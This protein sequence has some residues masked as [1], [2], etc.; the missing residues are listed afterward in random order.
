MQSTRIQEDPESAQNISSVVEICKGVISRLGIQ[1]FKIQPSVQKCRILFLITN[2]G[3]SMDGRWSTFPVLIDVDASLVRVYIIFTFEGKTFTFSDPE[4]KRILVEYITMVNKFLRVGLFKFTSSKLFARFEHVLPFKCFPASSWRNLCSNTILNTLASYKAFGLG[5]VKIVDQSERIELKDLGNLLEICSSRFNETNSSSNRGIV[6]VK[7]QAFDESS[8]PIPEDLIEKLSNFKELFDWENLRNDSGKVLYDN[9]KLITLEQGIEKAFNFSFQF[10]QQLF[11]GF[12]FL[13][14][15]GVLF[16][17]LAISLIKINTQGN[18][19]ISYKFGFKGIENALNAQTNGRTEYEL[20]LWKQIFS[21]N[22]SLYSIKA[23]PERNLFFDSIAVTAFK[24]PRLDDPKNLLG[25]GGF[26]TIFKNFLH[27]KPVAIKFPSFR[28]EDQGSSLDRFRQEYLI[29]KYLRHPNIIKVYGIVNYSFMFGI[30]FE[31]CGGGTMNE[32][33]KESKQTPLLEKIQVLIKLSSTLSYVHSKGYAHLDVKPHNVFFQGTQPLLADFGLA[34]DI[35]TE[36]SNEIKLGCTIYYSP[37]EQI[38]GSTPRT[39]FDVWAFGM[40]MYQYLT[41][42]HPFE[43]VRDYRKIQKNM[44]Y[45]MINDQGTRPSITSEMQEIIGPECE[46]MKQ[47]WNI[48]PELRPSMGQ[49]CEKLK[50]RLKL[51]NN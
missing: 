14:E 13:F 20:N 39:S 42:I 30:V 16:S 10:F 25:T 51:N 32:L 38:R 17:K 33:I 7:R 31:Y 36:R 46:I 37:P 22:L 43:H 24:D 29:T 44:F 27:G 45:H 4:L 47:C 26:G 34:S 28:K 5:L 6:N 9:R 3:Q 2:M 12:L 8:I 1:N 49:I 48:R 35:Y 41:G 18:E 19:V 23:H 11:A 21:L 40:T 50:S 15:Q